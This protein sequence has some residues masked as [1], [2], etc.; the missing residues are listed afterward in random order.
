M[1]VTVVPNRGSPPAILLRETYREDGKVKNRT[2]ANL[3]K[4]K[5]E[6]IAALRAVLR[7]E[8]LLPAAGFEI[9]RSLP[10][11]HIAAALGMAR[12]LGLDPRVNRAALMPPGA[13]RT[14]LLALAMIVARLI[15]PAAK[16][17]TARRLDEETA[18]HSLGA[19]LG[20][21]AVAVNELYAALDWLLAQQPKIEAKLARRHLGEGTLVLYDV[22]STYLEG[23]CCPLAHFGYSRDGKANKLQIVFGVL[24]TREG[25]PIAVEVFAGN[26]ADPST[27]KPQIDKL[28][29]RFGLRRVVL[30]GD[31]GMITQARISEELRPAGLDWITALRAPAIQALAAAGGPLQLSLFDERDLAEIASPDYPGERLIICRNPALAEE[32]ARKRGELLD[33]TERDLLAIQ[34]RVRRKRRPLR[35]A[36][37]IGE[38]VG[39]VL[40]RKKMAKHFTRNIMEGDFSF[41]RDTAAIAAEAR[42]DGVYVL[43][44]PVPQAELDAEATVRSYKALATVERAFRS[45]KTV[46]LEVR[47]V[48][49]WNENRVRAHVFLCLLAY[50]LEWHMRQTLAPILFDDHDRAAAQARRASPVSKARV[51]PAAHR[52]ATTKRTDD[53]HPVH[54]FRTLLADLATLTR[55]TVR[56]GESLSAAVLATPTPFQQHAFDLLGISPAADL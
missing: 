32:R 42:L 36:A 2:L 21:G 23:R 39:A 34:A 49:H 38:A 6:K 27:L 12:R 40:N 19:V 45:C 18:S 17:A 41:A 15:D 30:V 43:R 35:G 55:N 14:R 52:K 22:T 51:S 33:A 53:G 54:S 4:W 29:Q 47:P 37:A 13:A 9:L 1:Y 46:D 8:R 7:E 24:C 25:C 3:T 28:R 16:L 26:T 44:T 50:H 48:F 20:L 10:H 5:P 31:R 56:F 11:G